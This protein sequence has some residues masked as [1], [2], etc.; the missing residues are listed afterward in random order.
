MTVRGFHHVAIVVADLDASEAFYLDVL[1]LSLLRRHFTESGA[2]RASWVGLG[3]GSFLALER[4][5]L[6]GPTRVDEAPG[7][8]CVALGIERA[9]REHWA[10]RLE[11]AGFPLQRRT[12]FTLYV[13]DPDGVLVGLSHHPEPVAP[14]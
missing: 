9:A 12:A 13:R 4:A 6:D 5:G 1:G 10:E 8:H 14:E 11:R 3:D 2:H 7:A